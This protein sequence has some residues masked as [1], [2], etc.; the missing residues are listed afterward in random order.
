[1][2]DQNRFSISI[3]M[4]DN[5]NDPIHYEYSPPHHHS[6]GTGTD[7]EPEEVPDKNTRHA[8]HTR[9][10]DVFSATIESIE[11]L[12]IFNITRYRHYYKFS[13][14]MP[15][16]FI[17]KL[18]FYSTYERR[19]LMLSAEATEY[20]GDYRRDKLITNKLFN[21]EIPSFFKGKV[22]YGNSLRYKLTSGFLHIYLKQTDPEDSDYTRNKPKHN[23]RYEY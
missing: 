16:T 11:R 12:N 22:M 14:S 15:Y 8:P 21:I 1:M 23:P 18:H 9:S 5:N 3:T 2:K 10:N 20:S 17:D 7:P 19:V 13:I 6:T 4:K